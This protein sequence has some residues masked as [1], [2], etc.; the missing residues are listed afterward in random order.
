MN[1]SPVAMAAA[2]FQTVGQP[3]QTIESWHF[4]DNQDDADECA[5]LVLAGIKRATSSS[6]W[7]YEATN[8]ALP[9]IGDLNVVTNFA[10][11]AVCIIKTVAV[12]VVPYNQITEQYAFIEG[13][14]DRSLAYW[15]QVHWPYY[16]RELAD[17]GF[18]PCADM[19]IVCEQFEVVFP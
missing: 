19:P 5:Q 15:Q 4:C 10:G 17:T 2:Y 1:M 9:Q 7:W 12:D 6:L 3:Q 13:E 18:T 14:G 11:K 16:H 8:T